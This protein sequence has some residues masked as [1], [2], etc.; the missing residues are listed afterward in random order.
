MRWTA[1]ALADAVAWSAAKADGAPR[2]REM[3]RARAAERITELRYMR[4]SLKGHGRVS[5]LAGPYM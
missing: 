5:W 4:A 1:E 2:L 3:A